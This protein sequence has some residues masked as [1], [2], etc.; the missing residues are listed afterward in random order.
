MF[1]KMGKGPAIKFTT[2]IIVLL[3]L[4]A[5]VHASFQVNQTVSGFVT[6]VQTGAPIESANVFIA[7]TTMGDATDHEGRYLIRNVPPGSYAIV[8]SAIGYEIGKKGLVVTQ[9]S[10]EIIFNLAPKVIQM[11][12]VV[13]I[14]ADKKRRK[15]NI[16]KFLKFLLSTTRNASQTKIMNPQVLEFPRTSR[17]VLIAVAQ[18]PLLIEN[19][20]LGYKITYILEN[21]VATSDY[22]K[23]SGTPLF[24]EL[25]PSSPEQLEKWKRNRR[26]A[27]EGSLRHF[28]RTIC[29]QYD[30]SSENQKFKG[31][32]VIANFN[33]KGRKRTYTQGGILDDEGFSVL[34]IDDSR[35]MVNDPLNPNKIVEADV[36]NTNYFLGP[37]VHPTERTLKFPNYLEVTYM[38]ELEDS[39][40]LRFIGKSR[41]VDAQTSWIKLEAD[42]VFIDSEGRYFDQFKINMFGYWSWERLADMLPYEYVLDRDNP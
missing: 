2:G 41:F 20:A 11:P 18:E 8:V 4:F 39:R 29:Q 42:S 28:L 32:R 26:T 12:E 31:K 16:R 19:M 24:E 7:N 35:L 9:A 37:G 6:N 5:G 34:W 17:G 36:V 14:A 3:Y 33:S 1:L 38:D 40:Y 23:Y 25:E 22:V 15:K 13:V 30:Q 21:F 10:Q 27:Y